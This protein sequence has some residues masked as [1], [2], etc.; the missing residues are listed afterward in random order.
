MLV[1]LVSF[2]FRVNTQGDG[3]GESLLYLGQRL[4]QL[5]QAPWRVTHE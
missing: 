3:E 5:T 4:V 1:N 2:I